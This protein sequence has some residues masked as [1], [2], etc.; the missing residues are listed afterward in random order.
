MYAGLTMTIFKYI[1]WQDKSSFFQRYFAKRF[2]LR[3]RNNLYSYA[4]TKPQVPII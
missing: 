2:L 1:S 4:V 3:R